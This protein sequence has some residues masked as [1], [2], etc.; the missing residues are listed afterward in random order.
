MT[1]QTNPTAIPPPLGAGSEER[2]QVVAMAALPALSTAILLFSLYS[3]GK[4]GSGGEAY[5]KLAVFGIA[6]WIVS[7]GVTRLA[8]SRGIPLLLARNIFAVIVS[9]LSILLVGS[10]LLT[11]TYPGLAIDEIEES[12]L[13][14]HNFQVGA[15]VDGRLIVAEKSAELVPVMQALAEDLAGQRDSE[16]ST[17]Q[18]PLFRLWDTLTTRGQGISTQMTA[19]LAVRR[20]TLNTIAALR[21]QMQTTLADDSTDIWERRALYRQL[22]TALLSQL[23]KL[24][25]AV[26]VSVVRSYV[27]ELNSGIEVPRDQEATARINRRLSGYSSALQ[28]ALEQEQGLSGTAPAMPSKT[29]S[30]DT[31]AHIPKHLPEFGITLL[32]DVIFPLVVWFYAVMTY[33]SFLEPKPKKRRVPSEVDIVVGTAAANVREVKRWADEKTTHA[34]D[35][36]KPAEADR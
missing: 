17:G 22:Y 4:F 20:E 13:I 3:L 6:A 36:P 21:S 18:G 28:N 19:S 24:D 35:K 10:V 9:G 1:I 30:L 15:Y 34:A 16:G 31:F 7:Y 12:R 32:V 14:E 2:F 11:A 33:G 5:F 27:S 8:I 29:G 23:S 25:R 26:P